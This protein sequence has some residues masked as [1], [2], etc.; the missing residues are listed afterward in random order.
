M[1]KKVFLYDSYGYDFLACD[2]GGLDAKGNPCLTIITPGRPVENFTDHL[3]SNAEEAGDYILLCEEGKRADPRLV[4]EMFGQVFLNVYHPYP[5][6]AAR[7]DDLRKYG[8]EYDRDLQKLTVRLCEIEDENSQ[9]KTYRIFMHIGE[10]DRFI[11][12]S[13][14]FDSLSDIVVKL[15]GFFFFI[16]SQVNIPLKKHLEV[17]DSLKKQLK[18]VSTSMFDKIETLE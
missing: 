14:E 10:P 2:F 7:L 4:I 18:H 8:I 11:A 12:E 16:E 6:M 5:R 3:D 17:K 9:S 13:D 1:A 15:S